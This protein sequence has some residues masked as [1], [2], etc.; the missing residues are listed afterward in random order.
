MSKASS[1]S[2]WP[3]PRAPEGL[4]GIVDRRKVAKI[5]SPPTRGTLSPEEVRRAVEAVIAARDKTPSE[6]A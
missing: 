5:F 4:K 3:R 1:R 2:T 6:K